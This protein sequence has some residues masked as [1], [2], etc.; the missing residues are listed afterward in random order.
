MAFEAA[1]RFLAAEVEQCLQHVALQPLHQFQRDVEEIAGAGGRIEHA[2]F[3]ERVVERLDRGG[4][5]LAPVLALPPPGG[6][7]DPGPLGAK[8]PEIGGASERERVYQ[9]P[10]ALV[11]VAYLSNN[12]IK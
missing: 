5:V 6:G 11:H 10:T 12:K 3:A 4:G 7:L 9:G 2:G 1:E 8:R